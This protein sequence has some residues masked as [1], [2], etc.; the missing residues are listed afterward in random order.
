MEAFELDLVEVRH[1]WPE[2][3]GYLRRAV[4]GADPDGYLR[5]VQASVFA[6]LNTL[7]RI[8]NKGKLQAYAVTHIYTTDGISRVAQIHLLTTESMDEVLEL[9][10]YFTAWATNRGVEW[11]EV[12]GR[13]GWERKLRP[14]GFN[15]EYTSLM[16]HVIERIH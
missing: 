5:N 7:W 14:Y 15:H 4:Y 11:I 16:K 9:L 10:D 1:Y 6:G 8:E 2:A 3:V 13:K 12:I